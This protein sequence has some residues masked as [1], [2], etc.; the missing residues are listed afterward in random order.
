MS[1]VISKGGRLAEQI[2]REGGEHVAFDVCSKNPL[3]APLRVVR[4][5]KVLRQLHPDILHARSRV[6]AWLAYFANRSLRIPFVTTVHG[7]NS[8]NPYSRVMTYGDRVICVSNA[9][10]DHIR[11]HYRVSDGK[12]VV[13]PRGVDLEQFDPGR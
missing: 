3:T 11:H 6:P 10:R 12:I 5:E 8:V 9:I 2:R 7:F 13:I 4:L 1:I